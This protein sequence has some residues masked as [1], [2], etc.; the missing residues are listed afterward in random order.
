MSDE[1]APVRVFPLRDRIGAA[2]TTSC[3]EHSHCDRMG[4][5][6]WEVIRPEIARRDFEIE[7][8]REAAAIAHDIATDRRCLAR[9]AVHRAEQAEAAI[10]RVREIHPRESTGFQDVCGVCINERD[11][12]MPWPCPTI[13]A[14]TPS[15]LPAV[16]AFAAKH[17][18]RQ[19]EEPPCPTT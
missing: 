8:A 19:P 16:R 6:V 10:A 7:K 4:P 17:D 5:A 3:S 13:A 15:D 14:L 11:D 12:S 2:L 1:T 9:E 18:P